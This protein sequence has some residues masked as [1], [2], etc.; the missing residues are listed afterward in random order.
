MPVKESGHLLSTQSM[1]LAILFWFYK[2][3]RVCKNRLQIL[4]RYNPDVPIYGLYGGPPS[5]SGFFEQEL[6][7]HLDDFFSFASDKEPVWKWKNGDF[8]INEW[9][10]AR[11][12]K[13]HWDTVV[14]VQWDMLLFGEVSSV[15]FDLGKDEVLLSSLRPVED[16]SQEWFWTSSEHPLQHAIYRAFDHYL[17]GRYGS[18]QDVLICHFVVVCLSRRFLELYTS[19]TIP[20]LGF[21]EYRLPT[22]AKLL[23]V[24]FSRSHRFDTWWP[25]ASQAQRLPRRDRVILATG[26]PIPIRRILLHLCRKRGSRIFHP[27]PYEFP[28]G[29]ASLMSFLFNKHRARTIADR[30]KHF[31]RSSFLRIRALPMAL[32]H[33]GLLV[34]RRMARRAGS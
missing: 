19:I 8:L 7:L 4:R 2:D 12:R 10:R 13:L 27:F 3:L 23:K 15:F 5:D 9:F 32:G 11:G 24:Q 22:Y 29:F 25:G 30:I 17:R 18:G 1:L 20:E 33:R 14:L 31:L 6:G 21:V 34:M 16:V 26:R 28:T